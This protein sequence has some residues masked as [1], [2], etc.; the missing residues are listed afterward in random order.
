ML[1]EVF[2]WLF[3]QDPTG[4]H[5]LFCSL[6]LFCYQ[7]HCFFQLAFSMLG[8]MLIAL[9]TGG[10]KPCVAAFG[11][12]QFVLPQ[13]DVQLASFF[14]LFYF[15]I[16]AGSLISTFLTPILRSEH[17]YG[18]ESCFSLA[19]GIPGVL[20]VTSLVIFGLGKP[21]Y[22]VA[23]P[24]GNVVV[25]VSKCIGHAIKQKMN[26]NK[27]DKQKD[28][29]LDYAA[30]K[31]DEEL[32]NN[33]KAT[34]KVLVI[35][36][37][38]PVFWA[39]YDQQ[40]SGW[41]FMAVRMDGDIGFATILPDQMQVVNPF[42]ILSFIPLFSYCVYPLLAKCNLLKTPLQKMCCGGLLAALAFGVSACIS[43]W[44]E[45]T[46]PVLPTSGNIQLRVYNPTNCDVA[47]SSTGELNFNAKLGAN[48]YLHQSDI[49]YSGDGLISFSLASETPDCSK[50]KDLQ[51]NITTGFAYGIFIGTDESV[52]YKDDI[53][54]TDDGNPVVRTL[55]S[56]EVKYSGDSTILVEAGNITQRTFDI[57]TY[58]IEGTN[59]EY[60]FKLGGKYVVMVNGATT[61]SI[62]VTEPNSVHIL[63][64]IPQYVI[65]TAAE[66]MFSITGLEF[67]YS[68]APSSM[69]S[70]LQACWL[71]T[72]AFGNLIIV[73]IESGKIFE[74]QSYDF[75]LYTALMVLDMVV[76][77][78]LAT[79]YVYVENVESDSEDTELPSRN[80]HSSSIKEKDG[81]ENPTYAE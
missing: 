5:R 42:L 77:V 33:I 74:K 53:E 26:R 54:K 65:I 44:L 23:K 27:S 14:S 50:L 58:K 3:P 51:M 39:L 9:G 8:L 47:I 60:K 13:Q 61:S 79:R 15:S 76:F 45:S 70:V 37:P 22:K 19:F 1:Q 67:S 34:L 56:K 6:Q 73:I 80:S 35:Y 43:L 16:N 7:K 49:Q 30:G 72:T 11:G 41:T 12:D 24:E 66:I 71:L 69:K 46:Y 18:Q 28:H 31:Y 75:F 21:L 57:G 36:L 64:L 78:W 68:Q 32:I 62:I 4:F 48:A 2:C 20:M 81:I 55:S 10:I 17:C 38:L 59:G 40:G 29:W 52:P 63:W 25:Q